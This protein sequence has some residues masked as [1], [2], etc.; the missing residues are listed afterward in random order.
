MPRFCDDDV[1][2]FMVCEAT[3]AHALEE[4]AEA[5]EKVAEQREQAAWKKDTSTLPGG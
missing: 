3:V 5:E 1:M 4:Q 2:D